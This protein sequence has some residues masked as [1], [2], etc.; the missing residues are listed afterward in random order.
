MKFTLYHDSRVGGR[1]NNQDRLLYR[2]TSDA[3]LMVVADGM[4][5]H[6]Y[7]EVAS[8]IATAR[9]SSFFADCAKPY[10]VNPAQFLL[11]AFLDAH[12]TVKALAGEHP[13]PPLTTCVACIVQNGQAWWAHAGDSRFYLIRDGRLL[14]RTR[15]HSYVEGL[16]QRGL[17]SAEETLRHPQRNLVLSCLGAQENP[18]I[19]RD[20]QNLQNGD[21][22]LLCS[23]GVWEPLREQTLV[24]SYRLGE[25]EKVSPKLLD[26]AQQNAG[27]NADNLTLI[28]M[29]WQGTDSG[30]VTVSNFP[31]T[32]FDVAGDQ[33]GAAGTSPVMLD[34]DDIERAI[35][36][37]KTRIK[38]Q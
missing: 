5:G 21:V 16:F 19:D 34:E 15:D 11:D 3:L 12:E 13:R 1:K 27:D 25:V 31:A 37:I 23:D 6:S 7:G 35:A 36:D 2:Y 10:L 20:S 29:R 14:A 32:I 24:N 9:I 4:G 17:L 26:R 8:L 28:A 38:T 22:I 30:P 18:R 33:T